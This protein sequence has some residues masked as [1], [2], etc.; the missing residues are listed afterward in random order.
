MTST[1][2]G[3]DDHATIVLHERLTGA[4]E[5]D[6]VAGDRLPSELRER[7][8]RVVSTS[9][10]RLAVA[11]DHTV[12]VLAGP[13]GVGKSSLFNA[14][15]GADIA[16]TG[17]RRPTTS[18]PTAA[19]VSTDP[20]AELMAHLGLGGWHNVAVSTRPDLA[21]LVL[22]DLPDHDSVASAHRERA[23]QVVAVADRL[24]WV[25]DPE[26]YADATVHDDL[27][28]PLRD[29][30]GVLTVVMNRID[31]V[32][33]DQCDEVAQDL[34]RLL[35]RDGL[36]GVEVVVTS[37]VTGEG[38][39]DLRDH[40]RRAITD[41]QAAN[42][43]IAADLTSLAVA[44]QPHVPPAHATTLRIDDIVTA[45]MAAGGVPTVLEAVNG[46]HRH[47]AR[48]A[49]GWPPLRRF[50]ARGRDPL[51]RLGLG[52]THRGGDVGARSS[53]PLPHGV[54]TATLATAVRGEVD[55]STLDWPDS[56]TASVEQRLDDVVQ[57]L[58]IRLDRVIVA[59]DLED[60]RSPGWWT[61]VGALQWLA[62]VTAA[63]GA[64][65][66]LAAFVVAWFQLPD[67]PM[68]GWGGIAYATMMVVG[69]VVL[70]LLL[71]ALSSQLAKVGATRAAR[72]VRTRL[73][74]RV[75]DV[76]SDTVSQSLAAE[77]SR[78]AAARA[79]LDIVAG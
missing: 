20:V 61:A 5:L 8:D 55:R 2:I 56:W 23:A 51:G 6:R 1:P 18:Q 21:S 60:G 37:T 24:L 41:H 50:Q 73:Q 72:R 77:T 53:R 42:E 28:T 25:V 45:A 35:R 40:L 16:T 34:R 54:A 59:T 36:D 7:L 48:R 13:T 26:K 15:L 67:L 64:L 63:L 57:T 11:G 12:A 3:S 78:A 14:V 62:T 22:V 74:E 52:R 66:L 71:G 46:S 69:G 9:S 58:P 4:R 19:V 75:H 70:G 65:W 27:L 43:R 76:V 79:H 47:R 49:T 29:H 30:A 33:P 31:R 17:V 39:D 44:L 32:E 10:R 38:I 68:P